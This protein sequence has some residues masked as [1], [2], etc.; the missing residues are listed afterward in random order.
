MNR[1]CRRP[2]HDGLG[3]AAGLEGVPVVA[4]ASHDTAAA[5][6]AVP[7]AGANWAYISSGTWSLLGVEEK[8]PILTRDALERNFTSPF[9]RDKIR[10][11]VAAEG[12][13]LQETLAELSRELEVPIVATGLTSVSQYAAMQRGDVL[14]VYC[15]RLERLLERLGGSKEDRFPNLELLETDDA[16][17]YF[18]ARPGGRFLWASPVQV[19]LELMTGD[20]RDRETAGQVKEVILKTSMQVTP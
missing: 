7:A 6:A 15:P 1:F 8:M 16:T 11:K 9:I 13:A 10:L 19:Y 2:L 18:D 12:D 5:V 20:K 17:V 3:K 4:T 14:S